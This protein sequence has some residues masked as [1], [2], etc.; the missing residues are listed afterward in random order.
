MTTTALFPSFSLAFWLAFGAAVPAPSVARLMR[1]DRTELV[2]A[3]S[4][5]IGLDGVRA[6]DSTPVGAKPVGWL[7]ALRPTIDV[8][9]GVNALMA[10]VAVIA[11]IRL[12]NPGEN[13]QGSVSA[14]PFVLALVFGVVGVVGGVVVRRMAKRDQRQGHVLATAYAALLFLLGLVLVILWSAFGLGN[15]APL[16]LL[17]AFAIPAG[18]LLILWGTPA[19]RELFRLAPAG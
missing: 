11:V 3:E 18:L 1:H 16:T 19:T 7:P 4:D 9:I 17:I 14:V 10:I 12:T 8:A 15:I 13:V 6:E 5:D 2:A